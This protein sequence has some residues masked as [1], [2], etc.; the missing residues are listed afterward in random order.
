MKIHQLEKDLYHYRATMDDQLT[1]LWDIKQ[2]DQ[3]IETWKHHW[4]AY[5]HTSNHMESK[6]KVK[7]TNV[8]K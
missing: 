1:G 3:Q 2:K 4:Q 5:H 7:Y 6:F 8:Y